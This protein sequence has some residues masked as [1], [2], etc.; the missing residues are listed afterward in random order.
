VDIIAGIKAVASGIVKPIT[1]M[2]DNVHTSDEEREKLKNVRAEIQ[3]DV[4]MRL[5]DLSVKRI[6]AE[7]KLNEMQSSVIIAEA[8]GESWIQKRWRPG[9]MVLFGLIIF[10]NY[11]L[12]P[13][14]NAIF[15]ISITMPIPPEM[16]T[17]LKIGVGG[18]IGGR[19]VEKT[20]PGTLKILKN[21]NKI[22]I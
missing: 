5:L 8:K 18:Y 7:S 22:K 11:V 16:W 15:G 14:I 21:I 2:I 20:V 9:L 1:K 13:Y 6:E 17:L 19:T 10:N 12:N 4:Q 3:A